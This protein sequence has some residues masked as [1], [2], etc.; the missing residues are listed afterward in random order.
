MRNP[1]EADPPQAKAST[2][3]MHIPPPTY[4]SRSRLRSAHGRTSGGGNWLRSHSTNAT[5]TAADTQTGHILSAARTLPRCSISAAAATS[6]M[7]TPASRLTG[8]SPATTTNATYRRRHANSPPS[9]YRLGSISL[10][11]SQPRSSIA[12]TTDTDSSASPNSR[13]S[14]AWPSSVYQAYA[15]PYRQSP[16]STSATAS[17]RAAYRSVKTLSTPLNCQTTYPASPV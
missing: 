16:S 8:A 6:G 2:G 12:N 14:Q 13:V 17:P 5:Q 10:S 15:R 9:R 11:S 7:N 1:G 4:T 3:T